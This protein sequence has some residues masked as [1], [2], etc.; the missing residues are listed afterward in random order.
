MV[1]M[2]CKACEADTVEGRKFIGE[3][4]KSMNEVLNPDAEAN[5]KKLCVSEPVVAAKTKK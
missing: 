5:K 3:S 4:E 2:N 1:K